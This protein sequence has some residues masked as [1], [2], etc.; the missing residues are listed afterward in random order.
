MNTQMGIKV[1]PNILTFK[2]DS[3]YV[4][5]ANNGIKA[6]TTAL[7]TLRA[8]TGITVQV[9]SVAAATGQINTNLVLIPAICGEGIR[10]D[11]GRKGNTIN[12]DTVRF[13]TTNFTQSRN[14]YIFPAAVLTGF[15]ASDTR[16][17]KGIIV[18]NCNQTTL[19]ENTVLGINNLASA[20]LAPPSNATLLPTTARASIGIRFEKNSDMFVRCNMN[21][22][23]SIG[24]SG[25]D[26][27]LNTGTFEREIKFNKFNFTY[28]PWHFDDQGAAAVSSFGNVGSASVDNGNKFLVPG[29][30]D[31]SPSAGG[32]RIRVWKNSLSNPGFTIFTNSTLLTQPQS[33]STTA[34]MQYNVLSNTSGVTFTDNCINPIWTIANNG[35]TSS[36]TNDISAEKIAHLE[37][38]AFENASSLNFGMANDW[39]QKQE[40]YKTLDADATIRNASADLADYYDEKQNTIVDY[41]TEGDKAIAQMQNAEIE[42]L[43]FTIQETIAKANINNVINTEAY[44]K[45]ERF[46]DSIMIRT[47]KIGIDNISESEKQY[48]H[49]LAY[50]CRYVGGNAVLKARELYGYY[51]PAEFME[52]R[53]LCTIA[54]MAGQRTSA[55]LDLDS[56]FE[57]SFG[58]L[59][60]QIIQNNNSVLISPNPSNEFINIQHSENCDGQIEIYDIMGHFVKSYYLFANEATKI[61]VKQLEVGIYNCVCRFKNGIVSHTKVSIN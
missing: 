60:K 52:D 2:V 49:D 24:F 50:T 56:L 3:N 47:M 20:I 36:G 27:S 26:A 40:L 54:A 57:N 38:I 28:L 12:F 41:L 45:N 5:T 43:D 32:V 33:L 35:G 29:G 44:I 37:D 8:P 46:I 42:P 1:V 55:P 13:T 31:W 14:E 39:F 7:N 61:S 25:W 16:W 11:N 10:F 59:P 51:A 53:V 23:L 6:T 58:N 17:L 34:T 48:I 22:W 30:T 18:T 19:A 15:G 21:R 9:Q 4:V